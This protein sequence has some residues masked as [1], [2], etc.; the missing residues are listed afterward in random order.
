MG[1]YTVVKCRICGAL[2]RLYSMKVYEGDTTCCPACNKK[3][4][5]DTGRWTQWWGS[6]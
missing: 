4:G 2:Y 5:K 3:S 1:E 6:K